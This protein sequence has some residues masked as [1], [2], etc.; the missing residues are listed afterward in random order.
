MYPELS[1]E[2][3]ILDKVW[4]DHRLQTT[5]PVRMQQFEQFKSIKPLLQDALGEAWSWEPSVVNEHHKTMARIYTT[6]PGVDICAEADWPQII[7]FLKPRIIALD[8]LWAD[9]KMMFE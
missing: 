5:N 2:T 9:V 7:S 4:P 3:G 8:A 1:P 6:L